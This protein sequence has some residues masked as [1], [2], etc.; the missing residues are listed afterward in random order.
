M[1]GLGSV[2]GV[3]A[4]SAVLVPRTVL[5]LSWITPFFFL[6][7]AISR[8]PSALMRWQNSGIH[9]QEELL[10]VLQMFRKNF[11]HL[12]WVPRQVLSSLST[13]SK[14]SQ[15][16]VTQSRMLW[17]LPSQPL[18]LPSFMSFNLV[19]RHSTAGNQPYLWK[20]EVKKVFSIIG[21]KT[22]QILQS[23]NKKTWR[24]HLY[25]SHTVQRLYPYAELLLDCPVTRKPGENMCTY[26]ILCRG[27]TH[28]QNCFWTCALLE[29]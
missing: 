22:L 14:R 27:C 17:A 13:G 21:V 25:L 20:F 1:R 6:A 3:W 5:V 7:P 28:M 12:V 23:N 8:V 2:Q 24:G 15:S 18:L 26:S 10:A 11:V 16:R 19:R 9:A 4:Q 29:Q